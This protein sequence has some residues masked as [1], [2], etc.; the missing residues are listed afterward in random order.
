MPWHKHIFW[1]LCV[2][3]LLASQWPSIMPS[4][5]IAPPKSE[6][7]LGALA[8]S[9]KTA[10][11][12][13]IT[14]KLAHLSV[15]PRAYYDSGSAL[16]CDDTAWTLSTSTGAHIKVG[17]DV[18]NR[19]LSMLY[20]WLCEPYPVKSLNER[21]A[22][23]DP[24][25]RALLARNDDFAYRLGPGDGSHMVVDFELETIERIVVKESKEERYRLVAQQ[26]PGKD[27]KL[28]IRISLSKGSGELFKGIWSAQVTR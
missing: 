14:I 19:L 25:V 11:K 21:E 1:G 16:S 17:L 4:R 13:P 9:Q 3:G 8:T 12:K 6:I 7:L 28:E 18:D 24:D 22:H 26:R 2:V 15:T 10:I 23:L 27:G 5:H 20:I